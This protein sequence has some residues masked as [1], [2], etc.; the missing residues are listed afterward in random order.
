MHHGLTKKAPE[1]K[2]A[3]WE[4]IAT[5]LPQFRFLPC[6]ASKTWRRL[7]STKTEILD[8]WLATFEIMFSSGQHPC[9]AWFKY[10]YASAWNAKQTS[11]HKMRT[12]NLLEH[13]NSMHSDLQNVSGYSITIQTLCTSQMHIITL[14]LLTASPQ[15]RLKSDFYAQVWARA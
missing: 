12:H 13:S 3:S 5:H 1:Y 14:I 10:R 11:Q 2:K 15:S 8:T 6:I 7:I 9:N 4:S